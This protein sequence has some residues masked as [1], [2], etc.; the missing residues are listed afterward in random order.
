METV[1]HQELKDIL[2][3]QLDVFS[4]MELSPTDEVVLKSLADYIIALSEPIRAGRIT[5]TQEN[6]DESSR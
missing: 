1:T 6:S 2:R 3:T 5:F 4:K